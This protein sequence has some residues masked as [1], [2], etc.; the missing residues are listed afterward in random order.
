MEYEL[1]VPT[2]EAEAVEILKG[3]AL[4]LFQQVRH[5][6]GEK[7]NLGE[8]FKP[9]NGQYVDHVKKEADV[10]LDWLSAKFPDAPRL[11]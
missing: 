8:R 4:V 10:A 9:F 1:R 7:N 11:N 2:T 3:A 5:Y 6:R